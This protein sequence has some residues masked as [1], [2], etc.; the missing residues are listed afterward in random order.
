MSCA[1]PQMAYGLTSRERIIVDKPLLTVDRQMGLVIVT[2]EGKVSL[3]D[4]AADKLTGRSQR[5]SSSGSH[6]TRRGI[7]VLFTV[8]CTLPPWHS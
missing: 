7:R 5:R 6:T 2:P 4:F 1:V 8:S 3:I